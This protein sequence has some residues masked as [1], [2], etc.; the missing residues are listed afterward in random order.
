M[1]LCARVKASLIRPA[2]IR[3]TVNHLV[4]AICKNT[5]ITVQLDHK[6]TNRHQ[7]QTISVGSRRNSK[8]RSKKVQI[9]PRAKQWLEHFRHFLIQAWL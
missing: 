8:A 7:N 2:L 6:F 5:A 4:L 9:V 1:S 3:V